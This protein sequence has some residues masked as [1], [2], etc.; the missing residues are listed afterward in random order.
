MAVSYTHEDNAVLFPRIERLQFTMKLQPFLDI[1]E[2]YIIED[3]TPSLTLKL[4]SA[5]NMELMA[6][7]ETAVS[8]S[9]FEHAITNTSQNGSNIN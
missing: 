6:A 3:A 8:V 1:T 7:T 9:F 5:S 2:R 4:A